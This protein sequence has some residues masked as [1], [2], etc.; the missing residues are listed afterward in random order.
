MKYDVEMGSGTMIY[1]HSFTV[2]GSAIRKLT[3]GISLHGHRGSMM[4]P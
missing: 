2:I 3:R 1:V 4:I